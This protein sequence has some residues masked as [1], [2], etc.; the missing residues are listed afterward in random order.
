MQQSN[1]NEQMTGRNTRR[2]KV[3]FVHENLGEFGGAEGNIHLSAKELKH[4]GHEAALLYSHCTARNED[5][6]RETFS[7]CYCLPGAAN[8]ETVEAVL[9]QF[10]PDSIY[11][12]NLSDLEVIQALVDS[13]RP[14]VR[15]VHDHS[16]YCMRSYKYNYFTRKICT[17]AASSYCVFPC[18]GPIG[19][20][21]TGGWPLRW[22][23]YKEKKREIA[24]NQRC[25][26]VV[27]YS[28]YLRTELVRNGFEDHKIITCAPIQV[29]QDDGLSSSFSD[30]NLILFAGQ[31]IRGKGV[32]ALLHALAKISVP[33]RAIILGDGRQ[34]AQCERLAKKLGLADRVEFRGYI[35]PA[36]MKEFYLE[37]SV[38]AMSSLWP[39]P[40]GMVG[41][42]AMR[43]GLPVVAFDAGGVREWLQDGENGFLTPWNDTNA[44]AARIQELLL[45]KNRARQMG[46]C[47]RERIR[48]F[49]AAQQINTLEN[50]FH[51]VIDENPNPSSEAEASTNQ[52]ICL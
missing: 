4:R 14:V 16:L 48:R 11:L 52:Q 38:F 6:W 12:H 23:S 35:L 44:F 34:R 50:L 29:S 8:T 2:M 26:R 18:L 25:A 41:P 19:R 1:L 32:D 9:E 42:E 31:L 43:Y 24:L 40:F 5:A 30:R 39:E 37:A 49:D 46:E 7:E 20:S 15:M 33:F 13:G 22:A 27:T 3:L 17:R 10:G 51:E 36:E 21:K 28:D 47:G 45:D